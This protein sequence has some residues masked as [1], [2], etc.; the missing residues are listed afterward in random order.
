MVRWVKSTPNDVVRGWEA[1]FR[2]I[3]VVLYSLYNLWST[4]SFYTRFTTWFGGCTLFQ[5]Y[6][7]STAVL[8]IRGHDEEQNTFSSLVRPATC[9]TPLKNKPF[10]TRLPTCSGSLM[11]HFCFVSN[12]N[13]ILCTVS[14][15]LP[16]GLL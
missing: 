8:Q 13:R 9:C 2:V 11:S 12:V 6:V 16:K 10:R 1:T 4:Y 15:R 3:G 5:L 7:G 14:P